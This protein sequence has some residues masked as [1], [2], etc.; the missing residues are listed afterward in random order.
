[1]LGIVF[2]VLH[3]ND[4]QQSVLLLVAK[5]IYPFVTK[6]EMITNFCWSTL[7]N[8]LYKKVNSINGS[9]KSIHY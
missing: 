6:Q 5:L 8:Y 3:Q 1:M 9:S 7:F 2:N 4:E